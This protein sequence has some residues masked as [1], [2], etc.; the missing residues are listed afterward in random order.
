MLGIAVTK[1]IDRQCRRRVHPDQSGGLSTL[2]PNHRHNHLPASG[3]DEPTAATAR[4]NGPPP[5]VPHALR[6]SADERLPLVSRVDRT[7]TSGGPGIDLSWTRRRRC[8]LP[9]GRL[10]VQ[11]STPG[12]T[13]ASRRPGRRGP[14]DTPQAPI[15]SGVPHRRYPPRSVRHASVPPG[16]GSRLAHGVMYLS[17]RPRVYPPCTWLSV[18]AGQ[19]PYDLAHRRSGE[20]RIWP[21]YGPQR[22]PTIS[23][24]ARSDAKPGDAISRHQV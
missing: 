1:R 8:R 5:N 4:R 22:Q 3:G 21:T 10:A 11:R 6:D 20:T 18:Y 9:G 16:A 14:S 13:R 24:A 17:D 12:A 19:I 2:P 15:A 23:V 7:Y